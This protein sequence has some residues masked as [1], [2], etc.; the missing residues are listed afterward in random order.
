MIA[1]FDLSDCLILVDRVQ[2]A[3]KEVSHML[4]KSIGKQHD[5][6]TAGYLNIITTM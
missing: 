5:I 4:L 3:E 6:L 2:E 1:S